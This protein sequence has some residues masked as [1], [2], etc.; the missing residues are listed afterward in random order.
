M[1]LERE[2]LRFAIGTQTTIGQEE[3]INGIPIEMKSFQQEAD[4]THVEHDKTM[5]VENDKEYLPDKRKGL[6]DAE[7]HRRELRKK[8]TQTRQ[9]EK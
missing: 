8:D 3:T 2:R 6:K 4:G 9:R 7:S 5:N 1:T